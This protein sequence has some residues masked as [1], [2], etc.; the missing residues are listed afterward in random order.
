M[1]PQDPMPALTVDATKSGGPATLPETGIVLQASGIKKSY[2]RVQAL[3]NVDFE[4]RRSEIHALI[5]DNGAGKS[6]FI[7]VLSGVVQPDAGVIELYGEHVHFAGPKDAQQAGIETV[8]QDL[9]LAFTLGAA[10]NVYLG[11]EL[12]RSGLLGRLG[13]LDR[14]GMRDRTAAEM[15]DLGITLKSVRAPVS[16]LSGGQQ[17]A[18]AVARSALWGR[19]LLIMDEPTAALGTQQTAQ[20]LELMQR[21]R[22]ERG[23][24]I[25]FISHSMPL[26]FEVAD[27]ITVLRLGRSV[28]TCDRR[29][30]TTDQLIGAMTGSGEVAAAM[31][32]RGE[33]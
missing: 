2:G 4:L 28:L 8:Y 29:S 10:E 15:A 20:V 1:I 16:A 19:R 6:T 24:S 27:R 12:T 17:Q 31:A 25:L 22:D 21:A 7:K 14:A 18:V 13:F 33:R 32:E 30:A 11:R 26:V 9:A 3:L 5:G 23:V